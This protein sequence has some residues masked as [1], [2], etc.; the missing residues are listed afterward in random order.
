MEPARP[1]SGDVDLPAGRLAPDMVDRTRFGL[2]F[3]GYRMAEVDGVLDRLRDE[4]ADRDTE[5]STLRG[6]PGPVRED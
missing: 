5:L 2:A 3:R 1:D 6:E 4:I